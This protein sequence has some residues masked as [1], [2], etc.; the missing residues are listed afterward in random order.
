MKTTPFHTTLRQ[1]LKLNPFEW[2]KRKFL[3]ALLAGIVLASIL[4]LAQVSLRYD[5]NDS[6]RWWTYYFVNQLISWGQWT[7]WLPLFTT[8]VT[9]TFQKSN[10]ELKSYLI[11]AVVTLALALIATTVQAVL[12]HF[13][14]NTSTQWPL[15]RVVKA[16]VSNRYSFHFF[17]AVTIILVLV[18]RQF[19]LIFKS[20]K[21]VSPLVRQNL[22]DSNGS[23]VLRHKGETE[24]IPLAQI[25]HLSASGSYVEIYSD[26][27]KT[28]VTGTLKEYESQLPAPRF[29]RIHRSF[30]VNADRVKSLTPLTNEDYR[31]VTTSGHE[32]RVSRSYKE[33]LPLIRGSKLPG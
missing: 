22:G 31:L 9:R 32:L 12:W 19:I 24:F 5:S 26:N 21:S 25:S 13:I 7:L 14:Y 23:L 4:A 28:V 17:I 27:G 1:S 2:T 20:S 33:A 15:S 18:V 11:I 16:I 6:D 29:I 3:Y 10:D 8:F 30:I